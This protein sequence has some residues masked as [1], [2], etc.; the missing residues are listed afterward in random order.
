MSILI[1]S[2]DKNRIYNEKELFDPLKENPLHGRKET[3]P[4]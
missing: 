3:Q 4:L 2:A 1:N